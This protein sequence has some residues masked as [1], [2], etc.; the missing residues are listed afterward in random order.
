MCTALSFAVENGHYFGRNLDLEQSV[1]QQIV[2]MPEN[3]PLNF[4]HVDDLDHHYAMLG[5]APVIDHV[6]LFCDAMN[7]HGLAMAGLNYPG[8]GYYRKAEDGKTNVASF[9]LIPW[10]LGQCQDVD[11]AKKLLQN[12][13]VSDDA[14]KPGL[15]PTPL[16]WL[17]ADGQNSIVLESDRLGVHVYDNPVGVLT[18]NPRFPLQ[19]FNLNNYRAVS[20]ASQPNYFASQ[21]DMDDYS[22][23]LGTISLPG[24]I[25][26]EGRFVRAVFNKYNATWPKHDEESN[27]TELFHIMASV[28][29]NSGLDQVGTDP[30]QYEYTIY[31]AGYNLDQGYLYYTTYTNNQINMIDMR[32]TD[33]KSD[34]ITVYPF[35]DQRAINH[36]N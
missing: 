13:I 12:V 36:Q 18:N 10:V 27:V 25:D 17:I 6:P 3:F 26:S 4:R 35:N 29:Q 16:H 20:P 2:V 31:T 7:D 34:K 11:E 23:G 32:Q 1:G 8:N 24:G 5:I 21:V 9:E 19:L 22:R 15:Q 30:A 33:L 14:F 28:G